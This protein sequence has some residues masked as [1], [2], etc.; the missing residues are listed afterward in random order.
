MSCYNELIEGI[1]EKYV[2]NCG[3]DSEDLQF[4][5]V[6]CVKALHKCNWGGNWII[7]FQDYDHVI[8]SNKWTLDMMDFCGDELLLGFY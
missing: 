5:Y 4:I 6:R 7:K 8:D 1:P 3:V 2:I